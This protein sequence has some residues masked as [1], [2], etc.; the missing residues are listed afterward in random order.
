MNYEEREA[1]EYTMT[2]DGDPADPEAEA[3]NTGEDIRAYG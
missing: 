1:G 2:P 3:E